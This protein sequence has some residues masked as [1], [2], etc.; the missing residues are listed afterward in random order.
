M[1]DQTTPNIKNYGPGSGVFVDEENQIIDLKALFTGGSLMVTPAEAPED[2]PSIVGEATHPKIANMTPLTGLFIDHLNK[3]IDFKT[4][5]TSGLIK[6]QLTGNIPFLEEQTYLTVEDNTD[7]LPN[8]TPL[9]LLDS[10]FLAVTNG[11]DSVGTRVLDGFVNEIVVTDGDGVADDP[12]ISLSN[13]LVLPGT[14][15]STENVIFNNNAGV[16]A[17]FT[18]NRMS[19]FNYA[20]HFANAINLTS[21]VAEIYATTGNK[22]VLR[23]ATSSNPIELHASTVE[24]TESLARLSQSNNN[25]TF[26]N[27][28]QTFN[29]GGVSIFDISS[30]GFRLGTGARI[31][32]IDNT[33]TSF[34]STDGMTAL[35]VQ[36]AISDQI[37]MGTS[38][39]G[40]WDASGNLY[41]ETGG[42]GIGGTVESGNWWYITVAGT[43]GGVA[44]NPGDEI[45][46]LVALPGQIGS[47]WLESAQKVYSVFGRDGPVVAEDNDYSF[48]KITGLPDTA[49]LGKLMRGNGSAW[50]E[51]TSTF[52][53]TYSQYDILYASSANTVTGLAKASNSVLT[54]NLS[55][56]PLW[57][58]L[59]NFQF[60]GGSLA[61][62]KPFLI[63]VGDGLDVAYDSASTPGTVTV[64]LSSPTLNTVTG[65]SQSLSPGNTY[66][67]TYIGECSMPLPTANC[68]AGSPMKIITGSGATTVKI[69]QGSG[70]Q[71]FFGA[72]NGVSA[73]ST[74]GAGGYTVSFDPNTVIDIICVVDNTTFVIENC[75]NRLTG[76]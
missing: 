34:L 54:S 61:G 68:P 4:L 57:T 44:V 71:L 7:I 37:D 75:V 60:L 52:A 66:Y 17:T 47:N 48:D 55:S 72:Q 9:T 2:D 33:G 10:G 70:Q 11:A 56:V 65:S 30:S 19:Y 45:T 27:Q 41:P 6:V 63:T 8:S 28:T 43:L 18:V 38:F 51:T 15:T 39:R 31:N 29:I 20:T 5:L 74:L 21:A 40:G 53:D 59:G 73:A 13:T 62:P 1:T 12:R 46:A 23:N 14:L 49:T 69:T 16:N 22:V 36:T 24:I 42:T 3:I 26:G 35:G 64:S 25:I 50:L 32:N 58:E 76:V 67:V